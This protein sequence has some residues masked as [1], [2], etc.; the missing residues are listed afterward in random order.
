M[1]LIRNYAEIGKRERLAAGIVNTIVSIVIILY[2]D[3]TMGTPLR[4][5][6]FNICITAIVGMAFLYVYGRLQ[7]RNPVSKG[8]LPL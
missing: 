3:S 6:I 4:T 7:Q 1:K 2:I 8:K 5:S